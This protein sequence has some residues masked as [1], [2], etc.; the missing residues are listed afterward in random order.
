MATCFADTLL[1]DRGKRDQHR[2]KILGLGLQE[3]A[4]L[5]WSQTRRTKNG[6]QGAAIQGPVVHTTTWQNGFY[7]ARQCGFPP[8]DNMEAPTLQGSHTLPS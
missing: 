3:F 8:A 2:P 7:G 6:S 1:L 4:E 5:V